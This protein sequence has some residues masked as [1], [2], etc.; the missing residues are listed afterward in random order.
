MDKPQD[1]KKSKAHSRNSAA[2]KATKCDA[3]QTYRW[4]NEEVLREKARVRMAAHRASIT[5]EGQ[6][7]EDY[8]AGVKQ[9]HANYRSKHRDLLACKARLRRQNAFVTKHGRQALLDRIAKERARADAAWKAQQA[10]IERQR[11]QKQAAAAAAR[12]LSRATVI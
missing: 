2:V 10:E 1:A 4:K 3:S 7:S 8:A 11:Q 6:V 9:A 5:A 12:Q